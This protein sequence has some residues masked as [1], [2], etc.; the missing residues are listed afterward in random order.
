MSQRK[1]PGERSHVFVDLSPLKHSGAFA[2]LWIGSSVAQIGSQMTIVA[3][4]MHVFHLTGS[5][6]AVSLVAL[7]ALGP[8]IVAGIWGGM[9]ADV[10]DRR[11]V[12]L[13]TAMV[14]WSS[15]GAMT[16]IAFLGVTDVWPYY[17]LAAVNAASATILGATKSAIMPRLLPPNLIPA[18]SALQG[19]TMGLSVTVGPALAGV[20]AASVG[21]AWTY[22]VD[23]ILFT[24]AFLGVLTLPPIAPEG[25]AARP[26]LQSLREGWQ[27][28]RNA[29]NI[30][31]TFLFDII[32]MTLGTPRVLFPAVGMLVIGG[33]YV[34]TGV[35]TAAM[36]V[37]AL[38]SSLASG[39]LGRVRWQGRAVT[40][41]IGAYGASVL[42]FGCVLLVAI[43][44]GGA[45]EEHPRMVLL[46]LAFITLALAGASDNVSAIFRST[47]LQV[48]APDAMRGRLQGIFMVVVAGG[49]RLGDLYAGALAGVVALWAPPVFGGIVIIVLMLTL[50]R[51]YSGFIRYDAQAPTP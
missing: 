14:S 12:S 23:V 4:G 20:L 22:L 31:A 26:G 32:A 18:A 2:R 15:I 7:W 24:G 3:V 8:M 40:W 49:P 13:V 25:E 19:I 50:A 51:A 16:L 21:F 39:W 37:G 41:A 44:T 30:R 9:I 17:A 48:A 35:L 47:I 5:T 6:V 29:A 33:G 46:V 11:L 38:I 36:A 34:T 43:L 10:F 27:F 45:T 28:L 1:E 42:L